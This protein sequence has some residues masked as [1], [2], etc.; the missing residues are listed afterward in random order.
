MRYAPLGPSLGDVTSLRVGAYCLLL[1]M[2]AACGGRSQHA[3]QPVPLHDVGGSSATPA[4]TAGPDTD[5][6]EREVAARLSSRSP[7]VGAWTSIAPHTSLLMPPDVVQGDGGVDIIVQFHGTSLAE[8]EWR[9]PRRLPVAIVSMSLPGYGVAPYREAFARPDRFTELLD[10]VVTRAGG[11]H[12]RRVGL[13]SW[14]AGYGAVQRILADEAH[15]A[16]VDTVVLLDGLHADYVAGSPDER[17]LAPF[18]RFARDAAAGKKQM[19]VTH[20]SVVPAS[21]ASSAET[22]SRL[23][24]VA[25]VERI[26]EQRTNTLGMV[27]WY[28]ADRGGLHVR[29]YRGDGARDHQQQARLIGE[30]LRN[31]VEPRWARLDVLEAKMRWTAA[32]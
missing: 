21:Y 23:L 19:V 13:V 3:L 14:S 28:H 27:E 8:A 29:G 20:S 30:V 17:A 4:M 22:A 24:D 31:L 25:A 2:L 9:S 11:T 10:E 12:V 18:T 1:T 6:V 26:E 16:A 5:T 7:S 32:R 15:Y